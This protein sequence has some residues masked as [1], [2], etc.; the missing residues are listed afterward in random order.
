ME[1]PDNRQW[2]KLQDE[3]NHYN[4]LFMNMAVA[5][6][7]THWFN[8]S[9]G[10]KSRAYQVNLENWKI[11]K[12]T[13]SDLAVIA[14][15]ISLWDEDTAMARISHQFFLLNL[16]IISMDDIED[17]A[18]D[19]IKISRREHATTKHYL[20]HNTENAAKII[21]LRRAYEALQ[22]ER[23]W[24]K[25]KDHEDRILLWYVVAILWWSYELRPYM[26]DTELSN[27]ESWVDFYDQLFANFSQESYN[28]Y[29]DDW[30]G[31]IWIDFLD[32]RNDIAK[33]RWMGIIRLVIPSEI[34]PKV[35][36][37][38]VGELLKR[39]R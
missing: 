6:D 33:K 18:R 30:Y 3:F 32:L 21:A 39:S 27:D 34:I 22:N 15:S 2:D 36:R 1:Y 23:I 14:I 28:R 37:E 9:L 26:I 25:L 16:G 5:G 31:K 35:V 10:W 4:K 11:Q 8:W 24:W 29:N 12:L 19:M 38:E 13:P 20:I 7:F 17:H